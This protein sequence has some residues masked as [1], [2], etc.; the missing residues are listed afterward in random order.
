MRVWIKVITEVGLLQ[1]Q[2]LH[3]DGSMDEDMVDG[4]LGFGMG[5]R[6][7]PGP[8]RRKT[9]SFVG[10]S[11]GVASRAERFRHNSQASESPWFPGATETQ[12]RAR[13]R[14]FQSGRREPQHTPLS[15]SVV[16]QPWSQWPGVNC[17]M[18]PLP[19]SS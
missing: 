19:M 13:W 12:S 5:I 18:A 8:T 1:M 9:Q 3:E 2:T 4:D 14:L 11:D 7:A 16:Q 6:V 15:S 10:V 17:Q